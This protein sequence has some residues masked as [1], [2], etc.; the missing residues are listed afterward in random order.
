M[1]FRKSTSMDSTGIACMA[2]GWGKVVARRV[3][4]QVG[5]EL[6]LDADAIEQFARGAACAVAKGTIEE[7]LEKKAA[8]LGP[9]QPCFACQRLCPVQREPRTIQ[10][11]GAA[12]EYR[13]PKCHCPACRRDFS[14]ER[15][16]LRLTPHGYSPSVL[17]KI[18]RASAREPSFQEA[19][20]ALKDLAE[21]AISSRHVTR[22]A[23]EVGHELEAGRDQ[24]TQ[25]FQD[26]RLD[27][28][29]TTRPALAVVEVDGGRLRIRGA[30]DGP[31]AHQ[32]S[33]RE[34]KFALL[35]TAARQ[36]FDADPEPE[37]PPG[38][39]DHS[40]G[41]KVVRDLGGV[42]PL[43]MIDPP[44]EPLPDAPS[45]TTSGA[46]P[47]RTPEFLVRTYG[48][49]TCNSEAFGPMVAAEAHR[50]T[51]QAAA[52]GAFVG[53]GAAWLWTLQR[54]YFPGFQAVVDFGPVLGYV[55]AA[56]RAVA[57]APARRWALFL[58]WAEAC[59][60]GQVA[61]VLE[62]LRGFQG[63]WGPLS[64]EGLEALPEDDPRKVR[65]RSVGYLEHNPERMDY[66]RY[67]REGLPITS[68]HVESTVKRLNRR[69]KGT[70]KSWGEPGAEAILQ[71]RPAFLSD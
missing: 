32:A 27:P 19:A 66:P 70:E 2:Q 67:R 15:P 25:L 3:E 13:E 23:E 30:G 6:D 68:S 45:P 46:A 49:S 35:A 54:R 50:C 8:A 31:G 17:G 10:F 43:G 65:A 4:E 44:P 59:W 14:P 52:R 56:A 47:K 5:P 42:G 37:L 36:T 28:A 48:A 26:R 34:D 63:R 9:E 62:Q 11:W 53:D 51:F 7:L 29:V 21:V 24:Q 1:P 38:F 41:E 12:V 58:E 33:W 20:D 40:Y 22:I 16:A 71:L 64:A 69:V 60:H 39:R 55:F 61:Q 57:T 18:L